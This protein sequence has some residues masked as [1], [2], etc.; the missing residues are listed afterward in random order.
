MTDCSGDCWPGF[1][2]EIANGCAIP[3][4][5]DGNAEGDYHRETAGGHCVDCRGAEEFARGGARVERQATGHSVSRRRLDGEAG[6]AS[7]AGQPHERVHTIE[8]GTHG[9]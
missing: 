3:D 1:A 2:K 9:G 8:A 4:W 7:R 6:G 5:E